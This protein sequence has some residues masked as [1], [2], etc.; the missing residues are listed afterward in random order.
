MR[1]MRITACAVSHPGTCRERNEDAF[2]LNGAVPYFDKP[3]MYRG[4]TAKPIVAGVFDGMGGISAGDRASYLATEAARAAQERYTDGDVRE[5]LL[6]ICRDANAAVCEDMQATGQR[7]GATA[8]ML[9]FANDRA[10]VC[11]VGDSPIFLFRS[12]RLTELSHAHTERETFVEVYGEEA[13][14]PGKKFKL[15]QHIGIFPE[16]ME[17]EPHVTVKKLRIG[18]RFLICS[19][20]LTDMVSRAEIAA[21]LCLGLSASRTAGRLI[22]RAL[23]AGGKDNVT[24]VCADVKHP[25]S[26]FEW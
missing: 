13:I 8:S 22:R 11:N 7:M 1:G 3:S 12:S 2:Y 14:P 20:G 21:V 17:I 18:D 6:D 15:T 4:S 9:C 16:E 23:E 24:V 25:L 5:L 26:L 10:V 19:D